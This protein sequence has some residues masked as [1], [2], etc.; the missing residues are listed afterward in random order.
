ML[1]PMSVVLLLAVGG[2]KDALRLPPTSAEARAVAF[3]TAEVPRWFPQNHCYSCHNNGDAARALYHAAH[4]GYRVPAESLADTT[5]WLERPEAWDHNGGE[6]PF[7]DKRLARIIFTTTL[8]TAVSTGWVRDRSVLVRAAERLIRDQGADGSWSL[9]GDDPGSP[10]TY[11]RPLATFSAR[12][13]LWAADPVRFRMAIARADDWLGRQEIR[14]V[15]DASVCLLSLASLTGNRPDAARGRHARSLDVLR[16][17]QSDDGGWG[18][19]IK[20]PPEP[21]DTALALLALA[22][23]EVSREVRTMVTRGRRFLVEQQQ[24]DGGWIETT[25]PAGNVSY[26]QR[27]ST[28]GW[29]TLALLATREFSTS[30]R[31]GDLER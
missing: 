8:E 30:G 29:V 15:N 21:Y 20:S 19:E 18:P 7:S 5:R 24:E 1:G 4:A 26:A 11:G 6:G 17:G 2:D 27:I 9:D 28:A 3:L 16:R 23:S 12:Q 13:S 22:R 14:T 25:R 10:A 31:R